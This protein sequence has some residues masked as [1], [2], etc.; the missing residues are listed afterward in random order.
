[1]VSRANI[2][3]VFAQVYSTHDSRE[4]SGQ[5]VNVCKFVKVIDAFATPKHEYDVHAKAFRR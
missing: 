4:K 1:M 2:E 5:P 3:L